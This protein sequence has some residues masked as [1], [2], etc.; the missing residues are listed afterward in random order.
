MNQAERSLGRPLPMS[1]AWLACFAFGFAVSAGIA[2]QWWQRESSAPQRK[3]SSARVNAGLSS[4]VFAGQNP[5]AQVFLSERSWAEFLAGKSEF[6]ILHILQEQ[7]PAFWSSSPLAPSAAYRLFGALAKLR[8][9]T[10][11]NDVIQWAAGIAIPTD[12]RQVCVRWALVGIFENNSRLRGEEC[13]S[14]TPRDLLAALID[15]AILGTDGEETSD[16]LNRWRTS[17]ASELDPEMTGENKQELDTLLRKAVQAWIRRDAMAV[18]QW[19]QTSEGAI[20]QNMMGE[21]LAAVSFGDPAAMVKLS[22][23]PGPVTISDLAKGCYEG[24]WSVTSLEA[25]LNDLT[26]SNQGE[27]LREYSAQLVAGSPLDVLKFVERADAKWLTPDVISV[28]ARKVLIYTPSL[29]DKLS[30]NLEAEARHKLLDETYAKYSSGKEDSTKFARYYL[31]QRGLS[32]PN[33]RDALFRV[34]FNNLHDG[35]SYIANAPEDQRA[36]F[37]AAVYQSACSK[38]LVTNAPVAELVY[39]LE[40]TPRETLPSVG[41]SAIG[42]LSAK[43]PRAALEILGSFSKTDENMWA[44]FFERAA[45]PPDELNDI[46]GKVVRTAIDPSVYLA[47][48]SRITD[49]SAREDLISAQETVELLSD[50]PTKNACTATLVKRWAEV[51]PLRAMDYVNRLPVGSR[52]DEAL[53]ALLPRIG[54]ASDRYRALIGLASSPAVR[55]AIEAEIAQRSAKLR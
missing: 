37:T 20:Y 55:E 13:V 25:L 2:L 36:D 43:N 23:A 52:R 42:D 7:P 28:L 44:A 4:A 9:A 1:L 14:K 19:L 33:G 10:C 27:F 46:L 48:A 16:N 26:P 8:P 35:L 24:E 11:F 30:V 45:L 12:S 21:V 6:E 17:L 32:S 47:A 41:A 54:F 49:L 18:W 51:D 38:L 22:R 31:D 39:F 5:L 53:R 29:F 40:N 15:G 3:Q 34:A 50:A